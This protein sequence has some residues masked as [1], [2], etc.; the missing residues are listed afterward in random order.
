[1]EKE[2]IFE[3]DEELELK[4]YNLQ[5]K[6][7]ERMYWVENRKYSEKYYPNGQLFE[8]I[9]YIKNLMK[10]ETGWVQEQKELCTKAVYFQ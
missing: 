10:H 8:K 4:G 1:M 5:G 3:N 2:I 7:I 9:V 6:I